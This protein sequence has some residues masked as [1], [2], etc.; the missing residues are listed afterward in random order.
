MDDKPEA[1]GAVAVP[2]LKVK[3]G[4]TCTITVRMQD[5]SAQEYQCTLI[6]TEQDYGNSD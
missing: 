4:G 1:G 2:P 3:I 5:G 6:P